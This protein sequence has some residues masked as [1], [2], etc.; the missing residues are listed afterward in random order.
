MNHT[1]AEKM[2][3]KSGRHPS[4]AT[5]SMDQQAL[6][7]SGRM[8]RKMQ[9][10]LQ[11]MTALMD[12]L[13]TITRV[14]AEI[15]SVVAANSRVE[16]VVVARDQVALRLPKLIDQLVTVIEVREA[17]DSLHAPENDSNPVLIHA[18]C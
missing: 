1:T 2:E 11:A 15:E 14:G 4:I 3:A 8:R 7:V 10:R 17:D 18:S 5:A 12:V 16:L 9:V 6:P 13:T